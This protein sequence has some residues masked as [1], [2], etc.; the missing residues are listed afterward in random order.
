M[1]DTKA[2]KIVIPSNVKKLGKNLFKNLKKLKTIEI[3]STKL[4]KKTI[5]KKTFA[6]LNKKATIKVPKKKLKAYKKLFKTKG[7]NKKIKVK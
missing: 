2:T 6:G 1:N 5:D 3:K 7:L 4:T